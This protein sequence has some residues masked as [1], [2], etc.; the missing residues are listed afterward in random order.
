MSGH[1]TSPERPRAA[2]SPPRGVRVS[3]RGYTLLEVSIA[4]TLLAVVSVITMQSM[5]TL[6][7]SDLTTKR[8]TALGET[9]EHA[10]LAIEKD[11]AAAE[12]VFRETLEARA[13][14]ARLA[15]SGV[16]DGSLLPIL[17]QGE[18]FAA[19]APGVLATGN[20]LMFVCRDGFEDIPNGLF[21]PPRRIDCSRVVVWH[22]V[23][24]RDGLDLRRWTSVRLAQVD[25]VTSEPDPLKR[26]GLV[27]RLR[28]LGIQ[29]GIDQ[30][31]GS[32]TVFYKTNAFGSITAFGSED[33]LPADDD[34]TRASLFGY[35]AFT[36]A[37]NGSRGV[38][39]LTAAA[40]KFPHGF[41]VKMLGTQTSGLILL[42]LSGFAPPPGPQIVSTS[43]RQLAYRSL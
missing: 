14:M 33:R 17:Q 27:S 5:R 16:L 4:M 28:D 22:L 11:V 30:T 10:M 43:T 9:V 1:A 7:L 29:H 39:A 34:L 38:P 35:R 23:A 20:L 26:Q 6:T 15:L 2:V 21:A 13:C 12:I 37:P 42:R 25:D 31:P 18:A 36:V 41:E 3:A 32:G 8:R 24:G 19:D 40:P